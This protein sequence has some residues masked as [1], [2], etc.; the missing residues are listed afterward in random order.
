MKMKPFPNEFIRGIS[1]KDFISNGQVLSSAFQFDDMCRDDKK[2]EASIN[3]LDDEGAIELAL[4]QLKPN[5]NPQFSAGVARI[6]V[7][8]VKLML[9]SLKDVFS[10]ERAEL[11]DNKYHGNLLV[12]GSVTKPIK[13][14]IMNG[15]ALAAGTNIITKNNT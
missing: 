7:D 14:L 3:W 5:G 10:Y 15:L 9:A 4:N 8:T 13:L 6:N 12:D 11:E 2:L 1:N